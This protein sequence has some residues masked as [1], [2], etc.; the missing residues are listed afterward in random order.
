[1]DRPASY[2]PPAHQQGPASISSI[3]NI[4]AFNRPSPPRL[5]DLLQPQCVVVEP[6][7]S[8][9]TSIDS[10]QYINTSEPDFANEDSGQPTADGG[11]RR[12]SINSSKR[13]AQNRAAQRA[14]RL[15]RERYVAGLEEKARSFDRL[16]AAYMDIQRENYQLRSRLH[17]IQTE[18]TALRS[19]MATSAPVSPSPS[20]MVSA[21][22]SPMASMLPVTHPL[23]QHPGI[24]PVALV[25][26]EN[27]YHYGHLR[28][29]HQQQPQP[30]P[31]QKWQQQHTQQPVQSDC[32][33]FAHVY[34]NTTQPISPMPSSVSIH[35]HAAHHTPPHLSGSEAV[36]A[37]IHYRP[38]S[39]SGLNHSGLQQKQ[40]HRDRSLPNTL[41]PH[42]PLPNAVS[43]S[44]QHVPISATTGHSAERVQWDHAP[45]IDASSPATEPLPQKPLANP[46][47]AS[48][49]SSATAAPTLPSVREITMSIGAML[50]S[51]PHIDRDP[52][53][54]MH[55]AKPCNGSD[56][57]NSQME[58]C[59]D[60]KRRP[61]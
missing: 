41:N 55:A 46:E 47:S 24:R 8:Q 23:S 31:Q 14:F 9:G 29:Y 4:L 27:Y 17:K 61:W 5:P 57:S 43:A 1:M 40:F 34:A 19:H 56:S 52:P 30:M 37:G 6:S 13:A 54:Q 32:P 44:H 45:G 25:E 22:F 7:T 50:P 15:R 10:R 59:I 26:P 49:G 38:R 21:S 12:R 33:P 48:S 35:T 51:G 42:S 28:A 18:N 20:S 16:E 60:A 3:Q 53:A 58:E 2:V 36:A 39:P 11:S